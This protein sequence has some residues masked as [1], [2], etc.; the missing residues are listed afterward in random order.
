MKAVFTLVALAGFAVAALASASVEE[1]SE[2]KVN[3]S[4]ELAKRQEG[5]VDMVKRAHRHH[6]GHSRRKHHKSSK[7]AASSGSSNSGG[8]DGFSAYPTS[9]LQ[10][11]WLRLAGALMVAYPLPYPNS[12]SII[13]WYTGH[14]L[15]NRKLRTLCV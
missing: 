13:T 4:E 12:E 10:T 8:G 2:L 15:L 9:Q 1:R 5:G 11:F 7:A 14:D 6:R 3:G